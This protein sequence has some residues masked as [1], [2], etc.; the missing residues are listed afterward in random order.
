V[1]AWD[2][3][4]LDP[5]T[6][7]A[8]GFPA[9]VYAAG[10]R[11]LWATARGRGVSGGRVAGFAVGLLALTAALVSP[12]D[13]AA[14]E[15]LSA[16]MAQ[17]L[18]LVLVAAPL[19]VL[20]RPGLVMLSG[21]APAARRTVHR[22]VA[23][24]PLR[25][26]VIWITTPVVVWFVHVSVVWGW[27]VPGAYQAALV[28]PSVHLLEHAT[29]LGTGLLFWTVALRAGKGPRLARGADV[30]FVLTAWLQSGALG[31][32]LT[33]A[34]A[35]IYPAY[36]AS[37]GS[38]GLDPL[39]DQQVAGLIMWIPGGVVYL[40]MAGAMFVSWLRRIESDQRRAEARGGP[41]VVRA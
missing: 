11:S 38:L 15:L 5:V 28:R 37:S 12:L 31:A 22:V 36:V 32:L 33:F 3:W 35:P 8:L 2:G 9:L 39:R 17:H 30:L 4:N 20:G 24:R 13:R 16:H 14:E 1:S 10:V 23:W 41:G 25:M 29:F 27:H 19:L 7:L 40:V 34:P 6:L 18:V 21:L 26:A